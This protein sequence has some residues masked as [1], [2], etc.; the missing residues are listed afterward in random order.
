MSSTEQIHAQSSTAQDASRQRLRLPI[1]SHELVSLLVAVVIWEIAGRLLST[2]FLPPFSAV[3]VAWWELVTEGDLLAQLAISLE[4]LFIGYALALVFGLALGAL[5]GRFRK[6]AYFF[7]PMLDI[8]LSTPSIIYIPVL[9]ALFGLGDGTRVAIVF[10]YSFFII[11]V[12]TKTGIE[13]ADKALVEMARSFGA[14]ERQVLRKIM[15]PAALPMIMAGVRIGM[16]RAVKGMINGELFIALVGLGAQLRTFGGSFAIDKLLAVLLTI[17]AVAII[18][19]GI[20]QWIDK[21]LTGWAD[22]APS[23]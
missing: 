2:P 6:V 4:S 11:V 20:V 22:H 7:E 16:S 5:M 18:L 9:F 10:L 23:R 14:S 21:R 8:A 13:S 15:F 17:C 3:M 12:N 19:T 1:W